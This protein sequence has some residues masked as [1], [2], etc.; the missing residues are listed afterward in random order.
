MIRVFIPLSWWA[1]HSPTP[2][3]CW[4]WRSAPRLYQIIDSS[5]MG[6]TIK[7]RQYLVMQCLCEHSSR[8][9]VRP[10]FAVIY[11]VISFVFIISHQHPACSDSSCWFEVHLSWICLCKDQRHCSISKHRLQ[12]N[13]TGPS[14]AST[15]LNKQPELSMS[16]LYHVN[17]FP[18]SIIMIMRHY[19]FRRPAACPCDVEV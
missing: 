17:I 3:G 7:H 6:S 14:Y 2:V 4:D 13:V 15:H 16:T 5:R 10:L 8:H 9:R 18:L 19:A 12:T 1:L 11:I